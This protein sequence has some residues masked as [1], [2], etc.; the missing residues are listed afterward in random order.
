MSDRVS[1][2]TD[3]TS[4]P[5][6]ETVPTP[7]AVAARHDAAVDGP[8]D[9][10]GAVVWHRE[11]LRIRDQPAVAAATES[12]D[13]V[14]PLF[15]FDPGF[16]GDDGLACD[17]R[18]RFLHECLFD[19]SDRYDTA[20]GGRGGLTYAHGDP[21]AVLSAFLDA[22]WN[23]V[24]GRTPTGRYGLR[25]DEAAAEMGVRFVD[26]DGLVRGADRTRQ[27]W[28]DHMEAYLTDDPVEPSLDDTIFAELSTGVTVDGI[29]AT[30]DT[31]P[32]KSKVPDG[33]TTVARE[34]LESFVARV[35]DYPGNISSPLDARD[36][37]SGLSP[38]LRFGCLSVRQVYRYVREHAPDCRG[39]DM[40]E[41]RL[42]WNRHYNQK[43]EDWPGWLDTAV[44]PE[45]KWF[46]REEYDPEL[47]AAWKAGR[48]GYPMVDAAMRCLRETG[49]LNFRMRAMGASA[50]SHL[51]QQPWKIGADW[52]H[53][54]LVDSDVAINYTQWQSQAG[55]VGKPGIRLYNPRK[56]V[57]DQDP[58]GEWI[59]EWVP[60]LE[61]LPAEHLPQPERTPQD[62]QAECGVRIGGPE[63]DYPLPVVEYEAAKERFW[64]RYEPRQAAAA[65]RLGDEEVARRA[66]LSG[67]IPRARSIAQEY[68]D[69]DPD[70]QTDLTAF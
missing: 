15:V 3:E 50:F 68:G 32:T 60:E 13:V 5:A 1:R 57:R 11:D 45:L 35:G 8:D 27:N 4:P 61:G 37:C 21:L 41:S 47:V 51:L 9:P 29:E 25:R 38:Y 28:S 55:L 69:D 16:Y 2:A 56:Q 22:G 58:D 59:R 12:A 40:L 31:T 49:W 48:T 65:A 34:K 33:G 62:V 6:P 26:G 24:A 20:S 54:H 19:L 30:Y 10:D 44:N 42:L 23:V 70:T 66:S 53:H 18:I 46:N 7:T 43:L 67:G 64:R 17:A 14:V 36:G 63:A 52:Y 39:R